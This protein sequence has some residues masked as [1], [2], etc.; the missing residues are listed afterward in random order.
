[1][2]EPFDELPDWL[3][4]EGAKLL[5]EREVFDNKQDLLEWAKQGPPSDYFILTFSS[6]FLQTA[7]TLSED[8]SRIEEEYNDSSG[9][10]YEE[11]VN[12]LFK[13]RGIVVQSLSACIAYLDSRINEFYN[14]LIRE[15]K[16]YRGEF[17]PPDDGIVYPGVSQPVL[18]NVDLEPRDAHRIYRIHQVIGNSF[19]N[20]STLKKYNLLLAYLD[21][22]PLD[23]G[24]QP[25]QDVSTLNRL[26]NYFIH[27][28]PEWV[29]LSNHR[30]SENDSDP[31]HSMES[32]LK[33]K[34]PPNQLQSETVQFFPYRALS[35]GCTRW[36][37]DST[38]E[39]AEQYYEK[40]GYEGYEIGNREVNLKEFDSDD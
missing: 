5:L 16:K 3:D 23:K 22:E 2:S 27:Y 29:K 33:G 6:N 14:M 24:A 7:I 40:V 26:R 19:T 12:I 1:M 34:Y 31:A 11:G 9:P 30:S 15:S 18:G 39:F 32:A 28:E 17:S 36:A 37:I 38:L 35:A 25:Y 8:A 13:H 20:L 21:R 4:I 10:S